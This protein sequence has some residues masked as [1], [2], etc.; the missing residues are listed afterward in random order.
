MIFIA[1]FMGFV[2]E[3][4]REHI[5]DSGKEKNYIRGLYSDFKKDSAQLADVLNIG[6]K[7]SKGQDS[8]LDLLKERSPTSGQTEEIYRLFFKY[9]TILP[10]F[11][12]T[13]G[14]LNQLINSGNFRLI[15]DHGLAD[16]ISSYYDNVK[17]AAFQASV[18][19]TSALDCIQFSQ[20]I[21]KLDY[22]LHPSE[23]NKKFIT[24]DAATIEKYRNKLM[25]MRISQ[26]YYVKVDLGDLQKSCLH[27]LQMIKEHK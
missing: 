17:A 27:L 18:N 23:P 1:V 5:S 24:F 6:D 12:S 21:F 19:N 10:E 11:N 25:Q 13:E 14:T 20:N 15:E 16:S 9:A 7:L 26:Q 8:L 4:I 3:N 2:A 22:G